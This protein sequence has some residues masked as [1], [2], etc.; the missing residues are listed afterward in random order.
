MYGPC[1]CL[2]TTK[3]T[4]EEVS[5]KLSIA[6]ETEVKINSAREEYRPGIVENLFDGVNQLLVNFFVIAWTRY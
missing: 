6:A 4:S 5:E 3:Q 1:L 2:G